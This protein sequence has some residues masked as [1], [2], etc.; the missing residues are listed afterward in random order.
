MDHGYLPA[1]KLIEMLEVPVSTTTLRNWADTN[2][3]RYKRPGGKRFYNVED[4]KREVGTS[5]ALGSR[6]P[7]KSIGYARVSSDREELERQI[8]YLKSHY[9]LDEV[10]SEIGSGVNLNKRGLSKLL[11][12]VETG[13]V[14]IVVVT[15][16]D[17]LCRFGLELIERILRKNNAKLV[18]LCDQ[19]GSE[20]SNEEEFTNDFFETSN[21]FITKRKE[22]KSAAKR[23]QGKPL[24]TLPQEGPKENLD[25]LVPL[26]PVGLQ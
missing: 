24:Q 2:R 15:H 13:G 23:N 12:L 20:F 16:R 26:L 21:Y 25:Q 7:G 10:I 4:V 9:E 11:S 17:R 5:P 22:S 19:S 18:V 3:V 8:E 14:S 6:G 1:G